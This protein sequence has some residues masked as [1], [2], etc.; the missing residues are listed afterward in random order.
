M[1]SYDPSLPLVSLHIPK[2]AGTSL[3]STLVD[4]FGN[5]LKANFL[6]LW[7]AHREAFAV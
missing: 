2:T 4:W 1:R 7:E 5:D 3:R 6:D